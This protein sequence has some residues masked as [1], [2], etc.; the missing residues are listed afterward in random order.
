[1]KDALQSRGFRVGGHDQVKPRSGHAHGRCSPV[2]PSRRGP[3]HPPCVP[4]RSALRSQRVA[5]P[6]ARLRGRVL[7]PP[8]RP[9]ARTARRSCCSTESRCAQLISPSVHGL[10]TYPLSVTETTAYRNGSHLIGRQIGLPSGRRILNNAA[11]SAPLERMTVA[12][13]NEHLRVAEAAAYLGCCADTLRRYDR[14]R[15]LCA[16]PPHHGLQAL[17]AQRT[18]RA[19]ADGGRRGQEGGNGSKERQEAVEGAFSEA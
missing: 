11:Q 15:K 7:S 9:S 2:P 5:G 10:D 12:K 18:R 8:D 6:P 13:L 4:V 16:P 17:S 19:S 3:P 1:M 14:A